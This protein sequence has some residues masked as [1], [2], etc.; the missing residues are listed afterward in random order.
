MTTKIREQLQDKLDALPIKPGVYLMKDESG[1][2]LY[3][4]KAINLRAR[5]RSYFHASAEYNHKIQRLVARIADLDF[6]ITAS[7][8]EA[9]ILESNLV[10][11]HQPRYNI[12][13]KDDKHYPYLKVTW[14]E[15]Y[16]RVLIVRRMEHD[17]A[18]YFGPFTASWAVQQTLQTL[19]RVFPYLTCNRT[20]NGQDERA[21]LYLDIGL[22]LG[23]C[24]GAVSRDEYRVMIDSL[25][26]FLEGRSDEVVAGLEAKMRAAADQF[27]FE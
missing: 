18:R 19:R 10:K 9:L 14:Q 25:C 3:V 15:S 13:L 7:E 5:V 20:I 21:C 22:C 8:L 6:I 24:V 26:R 23:P 4:G 12:R 11:R 1:Q 17:G 2:I 27:N 16:P